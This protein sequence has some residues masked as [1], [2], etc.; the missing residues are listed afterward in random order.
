MKEKKHEFIDWTN[1]KFEKKMRI[2]Y[3]ELR[4]V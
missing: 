2:S 3:S 1:F 4:R